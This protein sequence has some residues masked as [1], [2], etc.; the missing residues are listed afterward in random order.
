MNANY[1]TVVSG[2][3]DN[4]LVFNQ[5]FIN[6]IEEMKFKNEGIE[7]NFDVDF[8]EITNCNLVYNGL[9]LKINSIEELN[10]VISAIPTINPNNSIETNLN[11]LISNYNKSVKND[12]QK[13]FFN[14]ICPG[15]NNLAVLA[16][17]YDE[18]GSLPVLD[19]IDESLELSN[20]SQI[21]L[22]NL[23]NVIYDNVIVLSSEKDYNRQ[24]TLLNSY[25]KLIDKKNIQLKE[26][27]EEIEY[28]ENAK[29][30]MNNKKDRLSK[31]LVSKVKHNKEIKKTKVKIL[32][33]EKTL[34]D[35]NET[36]IDIEKVLNTCNIEKEKW[37]NLIL[38]T[39]K[40]DE[41]NFIDVLNDCKKKN[42]DLAKL[43]H[44]C[45]IANIIQRDLTNN[46]NKNS[47]YKTNEKVLTR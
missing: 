1:S 41:E 16:L 24:K 36:V 29:N 22:D 20:I 17:M 9:E 37:N 39:C 21:L 40:L 14:S 25:D 2:M 33:Y 27:K 5:E 23:Q 30:V 46:L 8:D 42:L 15:I 35:L 38:K 26:T 12:S 3:I 19:K 32:D 43:E 45:K 47:Y 34:L 44:F 6:L 13:E 18:L 4:D 28:Y 10:S 11:N 31:N 7:I